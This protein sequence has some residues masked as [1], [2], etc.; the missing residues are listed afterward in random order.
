MEDIDQLIEDY[1]LAS[2]R[3][4]QIVADVDLQSAGLRVANEELEQSFE[5]LLEAQFSNPKS[6]VAHIEYLLSIIKI[7]HPDDIVLARLADRVYA[8]IINIVSDR[9]RLSE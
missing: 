5:A 3:L 9:E 7:M 1:E 8:N 6:V 2:A 4:T